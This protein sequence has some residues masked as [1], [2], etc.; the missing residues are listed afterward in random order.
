MRQL[1]PAWGLAG[2]ACLAVLA[3]LSC[4]HAEGA[5]QLLAESDS[6]QKQTEQLQKTTELAT[7]QVDVSGG[8]QQS[9]SCGACGC[10]TPCPNGGSQQ[11][12]M[13][14]L[15]P[16]QFETNPMVLFTIL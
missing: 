15:S 3:T 9:L 6:G 12:N 2:L 13:V 10:G 5:N 4:T 14:R 8:P 1:V 7:Y 16:Q 11:V